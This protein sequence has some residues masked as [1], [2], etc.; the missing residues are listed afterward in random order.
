MEG[1]EK[2][3]LGIGWVISSI[4]D[5]IVNIEF[6]CRFRDWPTSTRAELGAIWTAIL[7]MPHGAEVHIYTD[8]ACA[9]NAIKKGKKVSRTRE[10]LKLK[11][12]SVL[13]AIIECWKKKKLRLHTHKVKSHSGNV[14]N[15][16]ADRLAKK[17]A[18][19]L[20]LI[21]V[22]SE[23]TRTM[24]VY[25]QWE[26]SIID[27]PLRKFV[28]TMMIVHYDVEWASLSATEDLLQNVAE[29]SSSKNRWRAL[30]DNI[31][32]KKSQYCQSEKKK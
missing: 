27:Q 28:N 4:D 18:T 30:C 2:S 3:N 1:M 26:N 13:R 16:K 8:C 9:I 19:D 32:K 14:M 29:E 24:S 6:S 15:E 7:A 5:K 21:K 11:N 17:G 10:D 25:P 22:R 23:L 12:G 31:G 20:H